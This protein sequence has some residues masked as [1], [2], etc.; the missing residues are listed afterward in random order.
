[1][2]AIQWLRVIAV[3]ITQTSGLLS[4][5]VLPYQNSASAFLQV[6]S[7]AGRSPSLT[8]M[9]THAMPAPRARCA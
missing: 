6:P 2:A 3:S 5:D 4:W 1:M 7:N 9:W 8:V